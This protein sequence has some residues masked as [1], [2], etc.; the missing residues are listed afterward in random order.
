[1]M[2]KFLTILTLICAFSVF[3]QNEE[4][5]KMYEKITG[6]DLKKELETLK[7]KP[8]PQK[9]ETKTAEADT[10][11]VPDEEF[12]H[13]PE[14]A[15]SLEQ[16]T[17]FEK[18]VSGEL[19]DPYKTDLKQFRIDFS[20]VRTNLN[21][22]RQIPDAY[23]VNSG[24]VFA[25]DIWGAME[26]NYVIE[27]TNENFIIIPQIGKVDIS[28]MNYKGA[29][30]TISSKLDKI[31]GIKYSVRISE[32]KPITV[33]V[34]GNVHKP[35][36][37]NVSPFTSI[38]EVLA[39]AGGV[40]PEGSLR[41]VGLVSEKSGSKYIDLYSLI[42]FGKNP[43][44]VLESN[45][46]I[47]VP[48]IGKQ[49]AVAGNVKREGIFECLNGDKLSDILKIAGST[50]FSDT[51]RIE[52]ERLDKE[53]RSEAL[54]TSL[55][56]DPKIED[57]DIVRIF[58]TL[59]FNSKYVYLKGNFRHNKKIQFT[60]GMKLG[61]VMTDKEVLYENTDLNYAN[62][63]RK[64]GL[65]NRDIMINFSP[66]SV[67]DR[68]GDHNLALFPRDTV[69]VFSLDSV[70][71]FPSVEISGEI[72]KPGTYKFTNDMSV[73]NLLSF[74]GGLTSAG[75]FKNIIVIRSNA[76]N[77]FEY[78][79][80]VPA[81]SFLLK[82]NDKV[83]VF[84]YT[85]KNP[86]QKVGI[87]GNVKNQGNYIHSEGMSAYDLISLSGGFK[88]DA[89]MDSVEVVS[90]INKKN[91]VLKTNWYSL[92]QLDGVMLE[93]NDIVFVRRIRD[94]A[95]V[96]YVKIIGEVQFPGM[97]ALRENE[98][99]AD[100]LIRCGGF[101]KNAQIKSTQIFRDEVKKKQASKIKE[102][103][104]ELNNK[105]QVQMIMS[106]D[107]D[108]AGALNIAKFDSVEASG[109]VILDIDE[110]G[111]HEEFFFQDKDSIYVPP[112]SRTIIVMGEVYQQTAITFNSKKTEV[113]YYLDKVGGI[114]STG[115]MDN[116][117]V[118]KSNGELVKEKG[119][120]DNIMSYDLEPGD[121][122]YVPYNYDRI[123]FFQLTKDVTTI[124]YQLSLTAA[125]VYQMSN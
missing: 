65:G 85:A 20:S 23:E 50:P 121:M 42:F 9:F 28:G 27:V 25:I 55:K 86:V 61:D 80:E 58:S 104:D 24:D 101:T 123:D 72:K 117:Y 68:L 54:S 125:T 67:I 52:I 120:F 37:Y 32:V 30:N 97:Y 53:G 75:D 11:S 98:E 48:L 38:V 77:G 29:K 111:N 69:E 122:I 10:V 36:V 87:W 39:V 49:A 44:S 124:L 76:E 5:M 114:T 99:L 83:H 41:N 102:L 95:K 21:Y 96:N 35:G 73:S 31:N 45:M 47:F 22:N 88:N 3:A 17:Y 43:V 107:K 1:M 13:E 62:V 19:I 70:S 12:F 93:A 105:L 92:K 15:D 51:S 18:Y 119:W 59:V 66:L 7:N 64:N 100:L 112:V 63:I 46:T 6:K 8:V 82:A 115:D 118:I 113:K 34:V 94:Y 71:F 91:K 60:D 2:K 84:D 4:L 16:K 103:R 79:S 109:R 56:E 33:F 89:M 14:K 110:Q 57:G 40:T 81:D 108:L 116:I 26:K 74:C 78:F 106:G 90:G